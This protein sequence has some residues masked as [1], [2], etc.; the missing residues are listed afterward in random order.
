MKQLARVISVRHDCAAKRTHPDAPR[1]VIGFVPS[2]DVALPAPR[3]LQYIAHDDGH[4]ARQVAV[5]EVDRT[6]LRRTRVAPAAC[7]RDPGADTRERVA[8]HAFTA[9]APAPGGAQ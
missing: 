9:D 3:S 4:A 5:F 2:T 7:M 1:C 8:I 6:R